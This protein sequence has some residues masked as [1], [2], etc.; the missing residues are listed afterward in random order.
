MK[1]RIEPGAYYAI[2]AQARG[3]RWQRCIAGPSVTR[4]L[5]YQSLFA[6]PTPTYRSISRYWWTE[7]TTWGVT[8]APFDTTRRFLKPPRSRPKTEPGLRPRVATPRP[9]MAEENRDRAVASSP[10]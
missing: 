1:E 4:Y 6:S 5:D 9:E 10:S 8:R 2:V 7:S 3:C